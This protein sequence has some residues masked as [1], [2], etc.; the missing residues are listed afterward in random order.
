MTLKET[1]QHLGISQ[2]AAAEIIGMPLRTLE[3][4]V[5]GK[6]T[7]PEWVERLVIEKLISTKEKDG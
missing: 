5:G 2:R 3:A 7:P 6:R 1:I 4:W